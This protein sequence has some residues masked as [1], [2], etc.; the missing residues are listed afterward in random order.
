MRRGGGHG[1][2]DAGG[3]T[4]NSIPEKQPPV[5]SAGGFLVLGEDM[6]IRPPTNTYRQATRDMPR[7]QYWRNEARRLLLALIEENHGF[8]LRA[9]SIRN[10]FPQFTWQSM[11][12]ITRYGSGQP[13]GWWD[14]TG[15]WHTRSGVN[16]DEDAVRYCREIE[17]LTQ[18]FG[19][20]CRWGPDAIHYLVSR[21]GTYPGDSWW[22][23]DEIVTI[24]LEIQISPG[25]KWSD[26][27]SGILKEAKRQFEAAASPLRERTGFPERD[28]G[29]DN[30][31]R[32]VRLLYKRIC[33]G[34]SDLA[35]WRELDDELEKEGKWITYETVRGIISDT[36]CL[37][38]IALR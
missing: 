2:A 37:L 5:K 18:E 14:E 28:R 16:E 36:A 15:Q 35:I 1:Q 9:K 25:T 27:K 7:D 10:S 13:I 26:V 4:G 6:V 22:P 21:P 3:L 32:D 33:S 31:E 17:T 24:T 23:L 19:L 34:M 12:E 8:Q 30:L 11:L 38:G 20:R 29:P